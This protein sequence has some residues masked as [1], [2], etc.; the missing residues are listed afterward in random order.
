MDN[1]ELIK[2]DIR[3]RIRQLEHIQHR[4]LV[5]DGGKADTRKIDAAE[6]QLIQHLLLGA[7]LGIADDL[8]Q[9][10][11]FGAV[12]HQFGKILGGHG[13]EVVG[14]LIFGVGQH[15]FRLHRRLPPF[16]AAKQQRRK[17]NKEKFFHSGHTLEKV[18]SKSFHRGKVI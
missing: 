11:S 14:G 4:Q 10:P 6:G 16:A 3:L 13:A 8:D 2:S 9:D 17:D 7:Q 1:T 15:I 12:F 5:G 18:Y